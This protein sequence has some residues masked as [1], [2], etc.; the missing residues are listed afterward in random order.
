MTGRL[1]SYPIERRA[2]EIERLRIQAAAMA[3][4]ADVM[5][6]RIGVGPGWR[7]LDLGCGPGGI[8]ELLGARAGPAGR[9]VGLD[10]DLVLLG[11]ARP[12]AE[13]HRARNV[14]LVGGDAYRPPFRPGAFD[15]VHVRF[16][17]ST[18][19]GAPALFREALRL[20]RPGG[21][22]AAEEP[23]TETLRCYPAHPAWDR[24]K[25]LLQD[26]FV[27]VGGDTRLAQRLYRLF[28]GLGLTGVEYRPFLVGVT[29]RH[30]MVD[31]LPATIESLRGTLL[32]RGLVTEP[33]LDEALDAC[34][35]HLA[36]PDTVFTSYLVAQ[37]WGR[38]PLAPPGPGEATG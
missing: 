3:F 15:L 37:V 16:L 30:P 9:A 1:G 7:C 25:R 31:Y 14:A 13:L 24:L 21:V 32:G 33:E 27:A 29:S 4:D 12:W 5:L 38:Q 6:D 11:A 19:G 36:E 28:R 2:G 18:A 20:V 10:A 26:A 34:R 35:R 22:L 17:A 8:L 23:D